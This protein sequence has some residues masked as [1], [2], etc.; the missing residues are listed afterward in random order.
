[1]FTFKICDPPRPAITGAKAEA[2]GAG[3]AG[4]AGQGAGGEGD[5]GQAEGGEEEGE[6]GEEGA[7]QAGHQGQ[8][9]PGQRLHGRFQANR[10]IK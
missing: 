3:Q 6:A 1:M 5:Q 9:C 4:E 8:Q 7:I 2:E 10:F